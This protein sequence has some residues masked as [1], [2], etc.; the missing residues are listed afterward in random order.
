MCKLMARH[1][2]EEQTAN[3]SRLAIRPAF[4]P[5]LEQTHNSAGFLNELKES[6]VND[7]GRKTQI[8]KLFENRLIC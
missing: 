8:T 3:N 5:V 1:M 4:V 2:R 6:F 7:P